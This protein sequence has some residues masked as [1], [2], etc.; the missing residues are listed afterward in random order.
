MAPAFP[1][2]SVTVLEDL[3]GDG[4]RDVAVGWPGR[5][6]A[7]GGDTR[8]QSAGEVTVISSKTGASIRRVQGSDS[9]ALFGYLLVRLPDV[10]GDGVDELLVGSVGATKD[11]VGGFTCIS[12]RDGS[13]LYEIRAEPGEQIGHSLVVVPDMD[14]DGLP[15]LAFGAVSGPVEGLGKICFVSGATGKRLRVVRGPS[16]ESADAGSDAL[17]HAFG[18]QLVVVPGA[19]E[20]LASVITTT[21]EINEDRSG[22][23]FTLYQV[24]PK[25]GEIP[26]AA[27]VNVQGF[28]SD[29]VLESGRFFPHRQGREL[30][31]A[32]TG[33]RVIRF[34]AGAGE[35]VASSLF[36]EV[37]GF[38]DTFARVPDLDGDGAKEVIVGSSFTL[39]CESRGALW[40]HSSAK[41]WPVLP[42]HSEGRGSARV[43]DVAEIDGDGVEDVVVAFDDHGLVVV[44]GGERLR[45]ACGALAELRGQF[46]QGAAVECEAMEVLRWSIYD[47]Q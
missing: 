45:E 3:D 28:D 29:I 34:G 30:L 21:T 23:A 33:E 27:K 25:T 1:R 47:E 13:K 46:L 31:Y 12:L 4:A 40:V 44:L 35:V 41:D 6:V 5:T 14:G 39:G 11:G 22:Q 19:E 17:H 10:T 20:V 7:G 16:N 26:V 2:L 8:L 18:S 15:D 42:I 38:G 43:M 32:L 24:D 9:Q 37:C 36:D